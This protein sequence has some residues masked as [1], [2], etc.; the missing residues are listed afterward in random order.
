[1]VVDAATTS[2]VTI[3]AED[4]KGRATTL[5]KARVRAVIITYASKIPFVGTYIST[6]YSVVSS[7]AFPT[8]STPLLGALR[9]PKAF[10]TQKA[11]GLIRRLLS[12]VLDRLPDVGAL[13]NDER[14][15]HGL[16]FQALVECYVL[17]KDGGGWFFTH[18]QEHSLVI[19]PTV[20]LGHLSTTDL[21]AST[22]GTAVAS[23]TG[24]S[25][26]QGFIS[27]LDKLLATAPNHRVA[28]LWCARTALIT[29]IALLPITK[30]WTTHSTTLLLRLGQAPEVAAPASQFLQ[31]AATGMP[32]YAIGEIAKRYLTSQGLS[33]VHTR[34]LSATAPLNILLNYLLV[35]G[36]IPG[37]R[38][39]FA[40]APLC[41]T[42]SHSAIAGML[43]IYIVKRAVTEEV[44]HLRGHNHSAD[45][46]AGFSTSGSNATGSS[47]SGT[48]PSMLSGNP[49]EASFFAGMGELALAGISGVSK[50]ASQLWSKD[51]GGRE[52]G[53][54]ALATQAVLLTTATTLYQAPRAISSTSS[55]RVKKWITK[56]DVQRAKVAASVAFVGTLGGVFAIS[57]ILLASASSWGALFNNDPV[58]LQSVST[59]LPIIAVYQGVNGLGAWVDGSLGALGKTA[60][61]PAINARLQS[62]IP[63]GLYLAFPRH[64]GL[65][66]LWAGLIVSLAYSCLVSMTV[67]VT[68][69]WKK[70]AG[71]KESGPTDEE[72]DVRPTAEAETLITLE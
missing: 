63:L 18:V 27:A 41:T 52:L 37:L 55:D 26:V 23:L 47:T 57:N 14:G 33:K 7:D 32:G 12:P 9:D 59:L 68:T 17:A 50:S 21:A 54:N 30:L 72:E 64:W 69:S 35:D 45:E 22:I 43:V 34:I 42:L 46:E 58:I 4:A 3:S 15:D 19:A 38:L 16:L 61:F 66:G 67:L 25:V 10:V 39:G 20:S 28:K 51:I 1:M 24:Y 13:D 49:A 62:G 60:V 31:V 6:R 40:G 53:A 48:N 11:E 2:V 29:G 5:V 71:E 36:P 8:E 70:A 44:E 56:G 65:A